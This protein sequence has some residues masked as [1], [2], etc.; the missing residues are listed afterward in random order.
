MIHSWQNS[1][2]GVQTFE[3]SRTRMLAALNDF[4][5]QGVETSIPS[6]QNN[7]KF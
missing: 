3:E 7:S 1:L 5:I 4:Y 2:P 6:L